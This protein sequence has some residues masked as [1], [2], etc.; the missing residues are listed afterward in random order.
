V[1]KFHV[2]PHSVSF[3][4]PLLPII[5]HLFTM[6]ANI[7]RNYVQAV[8]S[9]VTGWHRVPYVVIQNTAVI[10][11]Q[12]VLK[13]LGRQTDRLVDSIYNWFVV[14]PAA[15]TEL[16]WMRRLRSRPGFVIMHHTYWF[17]LLFSFFL[18]L[19]FLRDSFLIRFLCNF[20]RPYYLYI[21]IYK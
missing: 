15:S 5:A 13:R 17:Y 12:P 7:V 8:N 18:N 14:L 20:S 6:L 10:S 2:Y 21:Q 11:A 1:L 9:R 19:L 3:I 16:H 4:V